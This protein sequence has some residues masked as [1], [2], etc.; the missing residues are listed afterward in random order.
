M[1]EEQAPLLACTAQVIC[2]SRQLRGSL[3]SPYKKIWQFRLAIGECWTRHQVPP[4]PVTS[5]HRCIVL[6][7]DEKGLGHQLD[8]GEAIIT[9][10]HVENLDLLDSL[11]Q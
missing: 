10:D 7:P 11:V 8:V 2:A 9:A 6:S 3:H 1:C 4:R 5:T